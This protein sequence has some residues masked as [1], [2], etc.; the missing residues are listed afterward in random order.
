MVDFSSVKAITIPNGNVKKITKN[1]IVL[2][3]KDSSRLP[4]EYQEVE[5]I[6]SSGTQYINTQYIINSNVRFELKTSISSFAGGSWHT[7]FGGRMYWNSS[8]AFDIGY[9]ASGYMYVNIGGVN[10]SVYTNISLNTVYEIVA[11]KDKTIVNGNVSSYSSSLTSGTYNIYLF[12]LNNLG[13]VDEY[14]RIKIYTF[15]IYEGDTLV[16]DY[17]PCYRKADNVIGM[18]DTV[19]NTFLT[20]AGSGT[21]TKGADV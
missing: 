15:K 1:N 20:N 8:D 10:P 16:K 3:E 2:W 12:A 9:S 4:S 14:G 17:V 13:S 5:Y 11:D 18:Y 21:F 6:E 7:L 19:T